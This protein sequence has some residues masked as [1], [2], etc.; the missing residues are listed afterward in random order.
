MTARDINHNR[1]SHDTIE[2]QGDQRGKLK[3]LARAGIPIV[4][5]A[6]NDIT[7]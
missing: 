7:S 6:Q 4:W 2:G 3:E 1:V 5:Q